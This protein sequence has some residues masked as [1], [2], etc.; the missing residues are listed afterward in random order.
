MKETLKT[1]IQTLKNQGQGADQIYQAI[2][3]EENL[4]SIAFF[5]HKGTKKQKARLNYI[6]KNIIN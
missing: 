1:K 4:F 2:A 5:G 6:W 3:G